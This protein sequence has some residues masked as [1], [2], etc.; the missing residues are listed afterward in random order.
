MRSL[1][2][3][4]LGGGGGAGGDCTDSWMVTYAESLDRR[5]GQEGFPDLAHLFLGHLRSSLPLTPWL[6]ASDPGKPSL[7]RD[8]ILIAFLAFFL[9]FLPCNQV[10]SQRPPGQDYPGHLQPWL[11]K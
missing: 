8:A 1:P 9:V 6:S 2:S 11:W 5:S 10:G 7:D 4:A 3:P